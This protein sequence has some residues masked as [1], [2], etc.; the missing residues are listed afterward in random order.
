MREWLVSWECI[1]LQPENWLN[2][3]SRNNAE[4]ALNE[5]A[6]SKFSPIA[7]ALTPLTS[8]LISTKL[9]RQCRDLRN[10]FA[11]CGMRE[12]PIKS[13]KAI[14]A[15]KNLFSEFEKFVQQNLETLS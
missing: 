8:H 1:Q 5:R 10:D 12:G 7:K 15:T 9:W 13:H 6:A 4:V 11:H 3:D 14:E 2:W